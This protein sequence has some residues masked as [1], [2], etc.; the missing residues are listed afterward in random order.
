MKSTY[1]LYV[2]GPT[3]FDVERGTYIRV[4]GVYSEIVVAKLAA[5]QHAGKKL[6]KVLGK[7]TNHTEPWAVAEDKTTSYQIRLIS[8][9]SNHIIEESK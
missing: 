8:I 7:W 1:L 3:E 2:E 9:G 6:N 5:Q 4:I